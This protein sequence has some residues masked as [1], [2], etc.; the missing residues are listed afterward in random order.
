MTFHL[1]Q[2]QLH[3]RLTVHIVFICFTLLK[4]MKLHVQYHMSMRA[5]D[6]HSNKDT[7]DVV[8]DLLAYSK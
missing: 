6:T 2:K 1:T 3:I 4:V 5:T 8:P 7:H